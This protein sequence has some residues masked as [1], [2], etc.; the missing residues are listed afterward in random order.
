MTAGKSAFAFTTSA[1][2][3]TDRVQTGRF[4]VHSS[5]ATRV[6]V[7]SVKDLSTNTTVLD[8]TPPV[9][10]SV[11]S[12]FS[13]QGSFPNHTSAYNVTWTQPTQTSL[14]DS[15]DVFV[16]VN[17]GAWTAL[18]NG[19]AAGTTS[20][21]HTGLAA[22]T[23]YKY[24]VRA[25]NA[26]SGVTSNSSANANQSI[27]APSLVSTLAVNSSAWNSVVWKWTYTANT[28]Q[29]FDIYNIAGTYLGEVLPVL[30]STEQT[31]TYSNLAENTAY[32]GLRVYGQNINGHW[33]GNRDASNVTTPYRCDC[34]GIIG[35]ATWSQVVGCGVCGTKT[36]Y[37]RSVCG[38]TVCEGS[39]GEN[40][41]GCVDNVAERSG[42]TGAN[43]WTREVNKYSDFENCGTCGRKTRY[44]DRIKKEGTSCPDYQSTPPA[45]STIACP[46]A[47]DCVTYGAAPCTT[48]YTD[49]TESEF[50][51]WSNVDFVGLK[52]SYADYTFYDNGSPAAKGLSYLNASQTSYEHF[53]ECCASGAAY[54][55]TTNCGRACCSCYPKIYRAYRCNTT[56]KLSFVFMRC[57][58]TCIFG[59]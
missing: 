20:F 37:K 51:S 6:G 58:F 7:K 23:N 10:T 35:N 43:G 2:V 22:S 29:R 21:L 1:F 47:G 44:W 11:T 41:C 31:W 56:Q 33:S 52:W 18:T 13:R 19:L 30:N 39:C 36:Q 49:V 12:A 14:I 55:C 50:G 34:T 28:Y 38:E 25:N 59:C 27:A 15:Y 32:S 54:G 5:G 53:S 16:S 24:Y 45:F 3:P 17:D 26:V 9:V 40:T 42:Q 48:H 8:T 4:R 46:D 57:T